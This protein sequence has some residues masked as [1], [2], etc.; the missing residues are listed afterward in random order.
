MSLT[1]LGIFALV[2]LLALVTW[3]QGWFA[4]AEAV[5]NAE[6]SSRP[7][8]PADERAEVPEVIVQSAEEVD[9]EDQLVTSGTVYAVRY[10][11]VSARIPGTLD[12]I[13]VEEGDRV[14]AGK[15]LLFQTD[16][17]K[18]KKVVQMAEENLRVAEAGL[19]EKEALLE[20]TGVAKDQADRD[21]ERY[22]QLAAIEG[23]P[24]QTVEHQAALCRQLAA[25]V[26]HVGTLIDLARAQVE[27]AR[28]GL[29]IAEKDFSDSLVLAPLS[30][31]VVERF[32]E[33]GEM[34]GAGT[35]VLR[36]EDPTLLEVVVYLPQEWYARV[37]PGKTQL[38]VRVGDVA[39]Q[40]YPVTFKS[41]VVDRELRTF[42]VKAEI[43][44][45][46]AGIVPGVLAEVTI[47]GNSRRSVGIPTDAVTVRDGAPVAFVVEN[48]C[49]RMVPVKLGGTFK[50]YREILSG[51]EAG[52][53]VV[54]L[55]QSKLR[56]GHPVRVLDSRRLREGTRQA[57]A[58][59]LSLTG[60]F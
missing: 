34:A 2:S 59:E 57:S 1:L 12:E 22:Q 36:I 13:F 26:K 60:R 14:E 54:V 42:E 31:V 32:R 21:L 18:L 24:T 5:F 49:A 58:S 39:P 4:A 51:L 23:I 35:P 48:H 7:N 20:K 28:L 16:S 55:G 46:P 17:L 41:P 8:V 19:R 43:P 40:N 9:F 33:P 50:G 38:R 27:Q 45:P 10:A 44:A 6:P 37:E 56:D 3:Q 53:P 29:A 47:V 52:T 11:L 15:T 25:D 30:G